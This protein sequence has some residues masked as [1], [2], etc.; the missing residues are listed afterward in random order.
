MIIDSEQTEQTLCSCTE[1]CK[2]QQKINQYT[3]CAAEN[4]NC[5]HAC[6]PDFNFEPDFNS[7]IEHAINDPVSEIL[8]NLPTMLNLEDLKQYV[9]SEIQKAVKPLSEKIDKLEEENV[10]LRR[11]VS[12]LEGHLNINY[13]DYDDVCLTGNAY[14]DLKDEGITPFCDR[15]EAL[16]HRTIKVIESPE[17]ELDERET[18]MPSSKIGKAAIEL[19]KFA[20]TRPIVDGSKTITNSVLHQFRKHILPEELRPKESYAREWKKE[21]KSIVKELAPIVRLDKKGN[22]DNRGIRFVFPRNFNIG[23]TKCKLNVS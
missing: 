9:Q 19:I 6:D 14:E 22:G 23:M 15:L 17:D 4:Y 8:P 10:R 20:S 12:I 11:H 18:Y 1:I 5:L 7:D 16:E 13:V 2:H 21:L 3:H